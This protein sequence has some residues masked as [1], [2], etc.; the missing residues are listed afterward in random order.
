MNRHDALSAVAKFLYATA[1]E[2]D[3]LPEDTKKQATSPFFDVE[4]T[5]GLDTE[6]TCPFLKLKIVP[7]LAGATVCDLSEIKSF[8]T[9][10]IDSLE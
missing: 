10:L 8:I 7:S 2:I 6:D 1:A 3:A 9:L 5:Q 4:V